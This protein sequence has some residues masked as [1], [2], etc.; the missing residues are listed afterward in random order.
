MA[1]PIIEATNDNWRRRDLKPD[2]DQALLSFGAD[3]RM[4]GSDWP[5]CL[6]AASYAET[7]NALRTVLDPQLSKDQQAA[8]YGLNAIRFYQLSI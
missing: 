7:L 4:F 2:V 8:V 6:L 1:G 5:V 3:R